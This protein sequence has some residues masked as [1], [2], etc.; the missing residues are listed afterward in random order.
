MMEKKTNYLKLNLIAIVILLA[1][2]F[3]IGQDTSEI[4]YYITKDNVALREKATKNS[5]RKSKL[6][7][8]DKIQILE[9]QFY[10]EDEVDGVYGY[11]KSVKYKLDS[12]YVFS[13]YI[14][15]VTVHKYL[16]AIFFYVV[17][18]LSYS[19]GVHEFENENWYTLDENVLT[20]AAK[21][22]IIISNNLDRIYHDN[23]V[24]MIATS[25]YLDSNVDLSFLFRYDSE[26][27]NDSISNGYDYQL[28]KDDHL[29]IRLEK[30]DDVVCD[31]NLKQLGSNEYDTKIITNMIDINA[32][33]VLDVFFRVCN[34]YECA[35]Y[36]YVSKASKLDY[37][38]IPLTFKIFPYEGC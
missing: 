28:I 30:N 29:Q 14:S 24:N 6:N 21:P 38:L 22:K 1:I 25:L 27:S 4:S 19:L 7:H 11:W 33:G 36:V 20:P 32:D 34:N 10:G 12:G 31:L 8:G 16:A 18:T 2:N 9:E 3:C 13:T 17:D 15:E 37:Q 23:K 5:A 35:R 26:V